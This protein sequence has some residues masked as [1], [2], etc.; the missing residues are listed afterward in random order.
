MYLMI[1]GTMLTLSCTVKEDRIACP[2]FLSEEFCKAGSVP[3]TTDPWISFL[4]ENGD[5][6]EQKD[7]GKGMMREGPSYVSKVPKQEIDVCVVYGNVHYDLST[8]RDVL[9]LGSGF[10]ADSIYAHC[11]KV[12]CR[13]ETASDTVLLSKQWC[14]LSI[15]LE[16]SEAW[17]P[18]WFEIHGNWNGM[19]LS[20][21]SAVKGTFRCI[22]RKMG[23]TSYE[24]RLPRQADDGL[25]LQV[26]D[27]D[28]FGLPSS[29]R[30]EYP[31]GVLME[32]KGYDWTRRWLSDAS[33]TIDYAKADVYV[34]IAPWDDGHNYNDITI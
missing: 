11:A 7:I 31:L 13:R 15:K 23:A 29:L 14:T 2:C 1:L 10:E 5:A 34:E 25:T 21:L 17:K 18:Y 9:V 20:D 24:A 26:Y 22:P 6:I 32:S 16:G 27:T 33:V 28:A 3:L 30:Y 8:R 4:G 19:D 12:D